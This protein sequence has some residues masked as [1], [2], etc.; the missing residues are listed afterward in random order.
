MPTTTFSA[1]LSELSS[2]QSLRSSELSR[3]SAADNLA[4]YH[5]VHLISSSNSTSIQNITELD[6]AVYEIDVYEWTWI[7]YNDGKSGATDIMGYAT[8]HEMTLQK[9][10]DNSYQIVNDIYDESEILGEPSSYEIAQA[11]AII[12]STSVVSETGVN[13]AVDL[14][15]NRL[16][17][18]ADSWVVHEYASNMQNSANYNTEVYGYYSADCA[19]FTSQCLKAGGMQNDYGDG[20]DN[21]NWDGTQWWFDTYPDP[22]YENYEVSPPSWRYVP[23]FIE[24]WEG[25]GYERVSATTSSVYP[26][27]PVVNNTGHVG[28]CVG[29][30]ASGTPIINAHNRDVYHVPYTMIGSGTRTTIQI[31]T[32]NEM[33]YKPSSATEITPTTT[34]QS[35]SRYLSEGSNHYYTFT[36]TTAGYYTFGSAYSGSTNLDT[37]GTLYKEQATSNGQTLYLYEVTSDD[38]SGDGLNF[39]IREYLQPGTYYVRVRAYVDTSTGSYS[40]TYLKG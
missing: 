3:M 7:Q 6:G 14:N 18:Y 33:V 4:E 10:A 39:S 20:K 16:I 17:D 22:N 15:V 32:S 23:K 25:Q 19:N 9:N 11:Q 5:N 28:I 38:D 36:V 2:N 31:A 35:I 37:R 34:T 21:E 27:N 13:S 30:N 8:D 40:F 29:Y 26:G 12:E 24:Y 1:A